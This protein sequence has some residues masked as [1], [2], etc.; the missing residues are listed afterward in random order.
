MRLNDY[1]E[2]AART[3]NFN[4]D[5]S[6]MLLNGCMGLCG[7]AGEVI[8]VLKKHRAQ[9]HSLDREKL[10]DELGDVMWY[11]AET[12]TALD[13]ELKDVAKFNI[14]KLAKRYPEGF[15]SDRSINREA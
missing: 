1:Q 12:A 7:E 14:A 4:L 5:A 11:V 15:N 3:I 2:L 10:I 8:D 13:I 6:E 9:G